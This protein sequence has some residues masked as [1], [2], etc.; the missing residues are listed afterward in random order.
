MVDILLDNQ[1]S[2]GFVQ[3]SRYVYDAAVNEVA[4]RFVK[5]YS[6]TQTPTTIVLSPTDNPCNS[7]NAWIERLQILVCGAWDIGLRG[8]IVRRFL[9]CTMRP[10]IHCFL[11]KWQILRPWITGENGF[12]GI[13]QIHERLLRRLF[14]LH[15]AL[16]IPYRLDTRKPQVS[17]C[18]WEIFGVKVAV[19]IAPACTL[20]GVFVTL[21]VRRATFLPNFMIK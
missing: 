5:G 8:W 6:S 21:F 14:H 19:Y 18:G 9:C 13:S 16:A 3:Q 7:S 12:V 15:V 2:L 10:F 4:T 17:T 11:Y 20:F 1:F